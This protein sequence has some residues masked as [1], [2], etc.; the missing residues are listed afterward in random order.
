MTSHTDFSKLADRMT[1][2]RRLKPVIDITAPLQTADEHAAALAEIRRLWDSPIDTPDGV[3][4]DHLID[5]VV[6][7]EEKQPW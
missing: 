5:L 7:Y 4:L 2:E 3:Q 1:P 6:V